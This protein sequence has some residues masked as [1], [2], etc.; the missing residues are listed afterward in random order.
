M[1]F[2]ELTGE[3]LQD[4][5]GGSIWKYIGAVGA[6]G[7]GIYEVSTGVGAPDGAKNIFIGVTTIGGGL[8]TLF[9]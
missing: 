8:F 9:S 7:F 5:E 4:I 1:G 6:I 2:C 3:Q